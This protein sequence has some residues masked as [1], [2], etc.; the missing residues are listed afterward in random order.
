MTPDD[1]DCRPITPAALAIAAIALGRAIQINVGTYAPEGMVWLTVG[2]AACVLGIAA[3][4]I[5]FLEGRLEKALTII[6]ASGILLQFAQLFF[7]EPAMYLRAK[8]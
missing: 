6:L 4:R 2:L 1:L 3:P 7:K 5:R 8:G